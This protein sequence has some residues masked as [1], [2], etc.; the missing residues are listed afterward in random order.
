[1]HPEQFRFPVVSSSQDLVVATSVFTHLLE[2]AARHYLHEIARCLD[3][4]GRAYI[5]TFIADKD[6][7]ERASFNFSSN[8]GLAAVASR[9]EPEM[10][11]GY[12]LAGW[13]EMAAE[14]NLVIKKVFKGQWRNDGQGED[15]QD[16]LVLIKSNGL[17]SAIPQSSSF[18]TACEIFATTFRKTARSEGVT[19]E[20]WHDIWADI[21]RL[22]SERGRPCPCGA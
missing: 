16:A 21:H 3:E 4:G 10:A 15:F 6:V 19:V 2:P 18:Q 5:T 14:S 13:E 22:E 1:M 7:D 12:S 11:V 20:E 9:D 8:F 17:D